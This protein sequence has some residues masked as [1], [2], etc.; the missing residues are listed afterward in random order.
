MLIWKKKKLELLEPSGRGTPLYEQQSRIDYIELLHFFKNLLKDKLEYI[1]Q[2]EL[3][4]EFT[5]EVKLK[6][7][8]KLIF[9]INVFR[10]EFKCKLKKDEY[11]YYHLEYT[12]MLNF[13]N[14][15]DTDISAIFLETIKKL[16]NNKN[17]NLPI[18]LTLKDNKSKITGVYSLAHSFGIY[19]CKIFDYENQVTQLIFDSDITMAER[20]IQD[21]NSDNDE[22]NYLFY[23]DKVSGFLLE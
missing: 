15:D 21:I 7:N 2:K 23:G 4:L 10:S 22:Y 5:H 17:Y 11:Y 8:I 13:D 19:F 14:Q 9:N 3:F 12:C 20:K 18:L 6:Y 1:K 16:Y